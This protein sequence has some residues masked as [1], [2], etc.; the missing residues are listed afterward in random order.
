MDAL[1]SHPAY[2]H[3][4]GGGAVSEHKGNATICQFLQDFLELLCPLQ[5]AVW[6]SLV[7]AVWMGGGGLAVGEGRRGPG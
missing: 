7:L 1:A 3:L 6:L 4:H 5:F 2:F